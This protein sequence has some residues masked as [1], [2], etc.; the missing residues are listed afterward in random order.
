MHYQ[1]VCD[2]IEDGRVSLEYV[3]TKDDIADLLMKP[4]PQHTLDYLLQLAGV[5]FPIWS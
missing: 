4:L 3:S 2:Y 1:F 5:S